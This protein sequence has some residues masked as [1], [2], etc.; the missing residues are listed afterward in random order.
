MQTG[1]VFHFCSRRNQIS[2]KNFLKHNT[3]RK[4]TE[5]VG[6]CL[7]KTNYKVQSTDFSTFNSNTETIIENH[8]RDLDGD[9]ERS[10]FVE[11]N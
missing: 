5:K 9:K 10:A 6:G 2:S 3:P 1:G 7:K 11:S 4:V 8:R